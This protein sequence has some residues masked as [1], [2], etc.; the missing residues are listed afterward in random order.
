VALLLQR[1]DAN[2]VG[3]GDPIVAL[4]TEWFGLGDRLNDDGFVFAAY[5]SG[6]IRT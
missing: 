5:S 1:A 6:G 2:A 4:V 3:V